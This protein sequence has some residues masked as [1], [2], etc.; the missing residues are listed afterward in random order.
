VSADRLTDLVADGG[1]SVAEA[2]RL[3][4]LGRTNLYDLMGRGELPYAK[5]NGRRV[6][7]RRALL[8]LLKKNLV[9]AE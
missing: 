6:I 9:T 1:V 7:P 3:T 5:I 4:S 2:V 8:E